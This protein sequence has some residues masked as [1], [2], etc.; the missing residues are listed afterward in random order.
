M[1]RGVKLFAIKQRAG[2]APQDFLRKAYAA[3]PRNGPDLWLGAALGL[4]GDLDDAKAA[5][6]EWFKFHPRVNSL[7]HVPLCPPWSIP[8]TWC[9][10]RKRWKPACAELG[11]PTNDGSM[12]GPAV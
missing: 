3:N 10:A 6:V 8:G 5:L 1:T 4:R 7:A 2:C 9:Y 12:S 11:S